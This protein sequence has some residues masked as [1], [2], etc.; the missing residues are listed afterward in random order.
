MIIVIPARG[1]SKRIPLKNIY[2]LKGKPLI[3]YTLDAIA[4][5]G[6][7]IPTYVSTDDTRIAA[8]ASTYPNVEIIMRPIEISHDNATTESVLLHILKILNE[9][10]LE[11]EWV[12]TLPPTSPFRSIYTIRKFTEIVKLYPKEVDCIMS[13]TENRADFWNMDENGQMQRLF[14]DAPRRQQERT[15]LYEEN[16][17]LYLTRCQALKETGNIFGRKVIGE[18]ITA[19]EGIDINNREDIQIAEALYSILFEEDGRYKQ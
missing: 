4:A 13:V 5:T 16:S 15:P 17:A 18:K 8:V 10:G 19:I 6:L 14:R 1:G 11:P 3:A 2:P 9:R 12:M 7:K